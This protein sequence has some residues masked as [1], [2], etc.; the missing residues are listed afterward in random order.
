[1]NKNILALILLSITVSVFSHENHDMPGVLPPTPHG[2]A[3]GEAKHHH[4]HSHKHNHH[5]AMKKEMF[6]EVVYLNDELKIYPLKISEKNSR[7]FE[8]IP[9]DNFTNPKAFLKLPRKKK[10][11]PLQL[12]KFGSY[13]KTAIGKIDTHRFIIDL[14]V[15]DGGESWKA[16]I[17]VEK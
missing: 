16:K 1:M 15:M 12:Q 3:L 7:K 6:F 17:Q 10:I 2:G 4:G 5:H 14:A 9:L 11:I 13:W 8:G